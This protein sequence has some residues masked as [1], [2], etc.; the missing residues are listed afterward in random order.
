MA[1]FRR[2][3]SYRVNAIELDARVT[4]DGVAIV[5]HDELLYRLTGADGGVANTMWKDMGHLLVVDREPIPRLVDVLRATKRHAVIHIEIKPGVPVAPVVEAVEA[6]RAADW[7]IL[8]SF[9]LCTIQEARRLAPHLPRML[10]AEGRLSP[11]RLLRKLLEC[12]ACGLSVNY[13]AIGSE[14][15][16]RW[17]QARGYSVWAWTVNETAVARRLARWGVDG[18]MG[19]NPALL[20]GAD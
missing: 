10:I 19:D 3:M 7:V 17:F 13:R 8:G 16:L 6:A 1:A 5:F 9:S 20:R 2:A 11:R 14:A 4:A 12:D 18:L 15:W